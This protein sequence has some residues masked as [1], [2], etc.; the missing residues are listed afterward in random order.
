MPRTLLAQLF[1]PGTHVHLDTIDPGDT[2]G[3]TKKDGE[4]RLPALAAELSTLQTLC[5]SAAR[6]SVLIVLQGMDTSGKDGTISHVFSSINPQGCAVTA[7]GRPTAEELAHDFLWRIHAHAPERGKIAVFNRSHYEDV[8]V[9]RVHRL[10][11]PL[12]W[13]RRYDR[14]NEFE[15]LLTDSGTIVLKFFLHISKG[16][17]E[18]RLLAREGDPAKAWKIDPADWIEREHWAAYQE[19]YEDALTKC[20]TKDALWYVVPADAKWFRNL[21]ISEAIVAALRPYAAEW[22]KALEARGD[23]QLAA[24]RRLRTETQSLRVLTKG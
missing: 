17:Q 16:E 21:A 13:K 12:I 10:V 23:V 18:K 15:S 4:K 11:P 9:A 8:L 1:A 6:N 5:Y 24:L 20:T 22:T 3:L 7:F 19:A 14:I 2:G